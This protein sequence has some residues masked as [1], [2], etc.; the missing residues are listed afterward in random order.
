[1]VPV[2]F[3]ETAISVP[4]AVSAA[5]RDVSPDATRIGLRMSR[6]NSRLPLRS[7]RSCAPAPDRCRP[8]SRSPWLPDVR[9]ARQAC[10][11]VSSERLLAGT[12]GFSTTS[13]YQS[14]RALNFRQ[15]AFRHPDAARIA[16]PHVFAF[17]PRR[18]APCL[19][20]A[21]VVLLRPTVLGAQAA[22]TTSDTW[23]PDG[24]ATRASGDAT[25]RSF[26]IRR[27]YCL[28]ERYNF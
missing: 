5:A 27:P 7:A 6:T 14:G 17:A 22:S 28:P 24:R 11:S 2:S 9:R 18:H 20:F 3:R 19:G 4:N 26:E 25:A 21:T 12:C 1:L 10:L 13:H 16:L 23:T 8:G 15:A